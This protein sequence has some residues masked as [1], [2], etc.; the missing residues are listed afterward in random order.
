MLVPF[1][2]GQ[3]RFRQAVRDRVQ[4]RSG[5]LGL[6]VFA[7]EF[8]HPAGFLPALAIVRGQ[9]SRHGCRAGRLRTDHDDAHGQPGAGRLGQVVPATG[10]VRA[11]PRRRDRH[12]DAVRIEPHVPCAK[13]RGQFVPI[14]LVAEHRVDRQRADVA[15]REPDRGFLGRPDR[16]AVQVD[17]RVAGYAEDGHPG[18]LRAQPGHPVSQRDRLAAACHRQHAQP[19]AAPRGAL[20]RPVVSAMRWVELADHQPVPEFRAHAGAPTGVSRNARRQPSTP[21]THSARNSTYTIAVRSSRFT[22]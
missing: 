13:S 3:F 1:D 17:R 10:Q 19:C 2:L 11:H 6:G 8:G 16:C 14:G 20:D 7:P 4:P 18:M 22:A 5:P 9:Q 21:L 12:L 15:Q